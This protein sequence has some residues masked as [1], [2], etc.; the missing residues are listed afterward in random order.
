MQQQQMTAN[1]FLTPFHGMS[2]L[3]SY[4]QLEIPQS[5]AADQGWPI[6]VPELW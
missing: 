4:S 6:W 1:H 3:E 2:L 5:P